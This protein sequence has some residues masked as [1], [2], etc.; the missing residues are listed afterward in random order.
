MAAKL[1]QKVLVCGGRE[2][3][4]ELFVCSS[5]NSVRHL[6]EPV[7]LGIEGGARCVDTFA[8]RWFHSQGVPH[9]TMMANWSYYGDSAGNLRNQWMRTFLEP[10]LVIAF[11]GGRGT[12]HM[13]AIAKKSKI[14]IWHPVK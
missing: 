9:V 14:D 10:D 8:K 6:F 5:L 3:D 11:P 7:F 1:K 13:V 12:A 2:F 4:D